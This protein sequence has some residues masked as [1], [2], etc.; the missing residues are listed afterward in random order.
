ML[1]LLPRCRAASASP[2][3]G[4]SIGAKDAAVS[5]SRC[6]RC[7]CCDYVLYGEKPE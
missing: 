3:S 6:F 5:P 2:Q 4:D 7:R 1:V